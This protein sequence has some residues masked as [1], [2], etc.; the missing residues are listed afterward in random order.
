MPT[1]V[2]GKQ[3]DFENIPD[4]Y[5]Y[6]FG[7]TAANK[8]GK[9]ILKQS[10][11]GLFDAD[12]TIEGSLTVAGAE[13]INQIT[14]TDT[15]VTVTRHLTVN[16][17]CYLGNADA[18]SIV[19]RAGSI[20]IYGNNITAYASYLT[21]TQTW[22]L[23]TNTGNTSQTGNATIGGTLTLTGK[24]NLN[25]ALEVAGQTD[26]AAAGVATNVRGTLTVTQGTTLNGVLTMNN[27][28]NMI[29]NYVTTIKDGAATPID[30]LKITASSGGGSVIESNVNILPF[31]NNTISLGS[32]TKRMAN[33]YT[34]NMDVTNLTAG[35]TEISGTKANVFTL[36]TDDT[37]GNVTIQFGT[38]LAETLTWNNTATR[39]EF[40]DDLYLPATLVVTG[41]VD[42]NSGLDVAG[43]DLTVGVNKFT[44]AVATG[45]TNVAGTLTVTGATDINSN[46]TIGGTLALDATTSTLTVGANDTNNNSATIYGALTVGSAINNFTN[47]IF[48]D[49]NF[50]S[51]N[52]LKTHIIYGNVRIQD[53]V[54]GTP[55][56][57]TGNGDLYVK[58]TV[59]MDGHLY[60]AG[61]QILEG[62][63]SLYGNVQIGNATTDTVKILADYLQLD[64]ATDFYMYDASLTPLLKFSVTGV[65]GNVLSEGNLTVKGNATINGAVTL[66]DADADVTT[67]E[68]TLV[69]GHSSGHLEIN[70]SVHIAQSVDIDST[71]NVDSTSTFV[72]NV[73]MSGTLAVTGNVDAN[74]G[75][76]VSGAN[77]TVA[78][79]ITNAAGT[80]TPNVRYVPTSGWNTNAAT[81]M[82]D[83][84]D[85]I[86]G[87]D[88]VEQDLGVGNGSTTAFTLSATPVS[89]AMLF[90]Y[91]GGLLMISD[92]AKSVGYDY[93]RSGTT[94]TFATAPEVNAQITARFL[95]Q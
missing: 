93:S 31:T 5:I 60:V 32:S 91:V 3:I 94:V 8:A 1:K 78:T 34:V 21:T 24:A 38:T 63:T 6:T 2:A 57:A 45:N 92:T 58:G 18:D 69:S 88:W 14:T 33:I 20:D 89:N 84:L 16:G 59:E 73:T 26:L 35:T 62:A 71:L 67:I 9:M 79:Q 66:G 65:N 64:S 83:A 61:T 81:N 41:N 12:L 68:G 37:G 70:D 4:N 55:N 39:F 85:S 52:S 29:G 28:I 11:A 74:A 22:Q 76:D 50:G 23:D 95:R 10:A 7:G 77:L 47:T 25:G 56:Y 43:A 42:A 72:G 75:L 90:L 40:S 54:P 48:G 17:S 80:G 53:A 30:V 19:M 87:G 13:I 27:N 15:D 46:A 82:Q 36:D 51:A 86:S 44:V 49:V